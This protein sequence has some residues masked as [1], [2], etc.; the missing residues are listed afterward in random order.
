MPPFR[1][2]LL[3]WPKTTFNTTW[4]GGKRCWREA[5]TAP[6]EG[7]S[8][9]SQSG[10]LKSPAKI[11]FAFGY[12]QHN[13]FHSWKMSRTQVSRSSKRRP[14]WGRY[15]LPNKRKLL[16]NEMSQAAKRWVCKLIGAF[17]QAPSKEELYNKPTPKPGNDF[18]AGTKSKDQSVFVGKIVALLMPVSASKQKSTASLRHQSRKTYHLSS[19]N[20]ASRRAR[21]LMFKKAMRIRSMAVSSQAFRRF[22]AV[23][24]TKA[25]SRTGQISCCCGKPLSCK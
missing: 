22:C 14:A 17:T 7:W 8:L 15:T 5:A 18:G 12:L 11:C 16:S 23:L 13:S 6:G 10:V 20:E 19:A 24:A 21:Q 25:A 4:L 9:E 1:W 2:V 3:S